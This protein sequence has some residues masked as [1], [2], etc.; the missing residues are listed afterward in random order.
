MKINLEQDEIDF[1]TECI[2][3][4]IV[5]DASRTDVPIEY[6]NIIESWRAEGQMILAKLERCE[7]SKKEH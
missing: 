5:N 1:I 2:E 4:R 7:D 6:I 3:T